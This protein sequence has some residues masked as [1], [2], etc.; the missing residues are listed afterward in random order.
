MRPAAD[1]LGLGGTWTDPTWRTT[2]TLTAL[3]RDL[4]RTWWVRRL[5][6]IAHAGAA[7]LVTT[8][9]YSRL[10]HSLGVLALVAHFHPDDVLTRAGALLH[11][12]GHLPFSHTLEGLAGLDHHQLGEQRLHDL[13]PVLA[14]HGLDED[15]VDAVAA[16]A[17]GSRPG[18]LSAP[19]GEL[20][21]DHLD[22]FV[23]SA[24]AHGRPLLD[25]RQLLERLTLTGGVVT[26]DPATADHLDDLVL[27]EARS[28]TAEVNVVATGLLRHWAGLL[29]HDAPAEQR[30]RTAAST[31]EELWWSL[32]TDE[33]T[34]AEVERFRRD[35]LQWAVTDPDAVGHG[36]TGTRHTVRRLYLS[37]PRVPGEVPGARTAR[38]AARLP[39]TPVSFV[40]HRT[41]S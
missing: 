26:T 11:D 29:L 34:A 27:A 18:P 2:L 16:A 22:S 10:E 20:S 39:P 40:V 24:R 41:P 38:I 19:R 9:N 6:F 7:A 15:D 33:R 3:E 8:Q 5:Q 14:R 25:P 13:T 35:P 4:L 12:I 36:T 1:T 17:T 21:L 23:R 32:R 28:Q 30:T 37:A 31:D